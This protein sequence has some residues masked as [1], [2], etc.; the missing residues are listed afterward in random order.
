MHISKTLKTAAM[1]AAVAVAGTSAMAAGSDTGVEAGFYALGQ[2]LN[3]IL[4]G[5]GGYVILIL[6][7]IIGGA[8]LAV[9]GRWGHV[10]IAIGVAVF[11]GYGVQT[12]TS[13]GG[14]TA[15]TDLL[16]L[17]AVEAPVSETVTQ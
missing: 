14:V 9:T 15:S 13:L 11:L 5:A 10:F 1:A 17:P 7:V 8:T 2:D 4:D 16:E 12:A 3:T 6:S